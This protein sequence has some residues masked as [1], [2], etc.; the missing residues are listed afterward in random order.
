MKK[1]LTIAVALLTS[2]I[3]A[4]AQWAIDSISTAAYNMVP[5]QVGS[6]VILA[7]SSKYETFDFATNQWSSKLMPGPRTGVLGAE[8]LGKVYFGGGGFIT[9]SNQVMF[10]YVDI[11]NSLTNSWSTTN[12]S[13]ARMTGAAVS[14]GNKVM[15]AGGR[16]VLS[17]SSRVDI[18]DVN[19]GVRTTATLSQARHAIAVGKVGSKVVFAGGECGSIINGSYTSSNK[20][21]IYDDVNGTWS[22]ALLSVK[23]ERIAVGVVGTKIIFAGGMNNSGYSN[24]VDIYDAATNTWST[25]LLSQRKYGMA[26]ATNGTKVYFAGGTYSNSGALSDRVEIYDAATNTW[27]FIKISSPRMNMVVAKTPGRI[28]F[29]GGIVTWGN[30]GTDRVEVLDLNSNT[31]SVEHLSRPRLGIAPV[32]YGN[33]ALFVGGAEVL[34]S[35]PQYS[36]ISK[37]V[38][39]WTDPS[40][41]IVSKVQTMNEESSLAI[42]PNP[43]DGTSIQISFKQAEERAVQ[44]KVYDMSGRMVYTHTTDNATEIFETIDVST[45]VAGTYLFSA[46]SGAQRKETKLIIVK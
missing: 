7:S 6:Q 32:S 9:V 13:Q 3:S 23:R 43:S 22:T 45:L 38:D 8:A 11:Y 30:V 4:N 46:E 25:A 18:F 20:V 34:S 19:T 29:A 5:V 2:I 16:Q 10:K 21:D 26:V 15:F 31:W 1:I 14:V 40:P 27:S 24:Q 33:K 37:R 35:Y 17:Y 41:A 12:L 28:M 44:F 39:I 42:Y 36:I